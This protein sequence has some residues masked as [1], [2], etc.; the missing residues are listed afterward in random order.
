MTKEQ[1]KYHGEWV[2]FQQIAL[3]QN[4]YWH[5]TTTKKNSDTDLTTY[6]KI[7]SKWITDLTVNLKVIKLLEKKIRGN[8]SDLEFVNNFLDTTTEAGSM[9]EKKEKKEWVGVH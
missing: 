3:G 2:S 1:S 6:T 7:N 9:K 5:T 4:E 8:L